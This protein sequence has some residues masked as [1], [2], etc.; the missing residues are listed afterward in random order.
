MP[1]KDAETVV[2][3]LLDSKAVSTKMAG[4]AVRDVLRTEAGLCL[5]GNELNEETT[6]I[7][8]GIAFVIGQFPLHVLLE[9]DESGFCVSAKR[10]RQTLGF[11]GAEKIME[12][13]EKKN[14]P[15]KR[16]GLVATK[17]AERR[18]VFFFF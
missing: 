12:Q 10:R 13:L 14:A 15:K 11:P 6:P 2:Q 7:E 5:Y 8:A 9:L 3:R 16:V 4:L 1:S 17:A 18:E